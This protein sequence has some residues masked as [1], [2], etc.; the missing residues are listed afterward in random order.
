MNADLDYIYD[1]TDAYLIIILIM[2]MP[3]LMIFST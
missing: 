3:N 2:T 1:K